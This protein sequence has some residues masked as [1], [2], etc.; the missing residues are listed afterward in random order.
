MFQFCI[1]TIKPLSQSVAILAPAWHGVIE[2]NVPGQA[3]M[4]SHVVLD[5]HLS[6][7]LLVAPSGLEYAL[8]FQG[9][10][11]LHDAAISEQI[12]ELPESQQPIE[13]A[14]KDTCCKSC[15]PLWK[16]FKLKSSIR[17][18]G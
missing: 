9:K 18:G 10:V 5:K 11:S 14:S 8:A 13:K 2:D 7:S 17:K 4:V 6:V 15:H 12:F 1:G 3:T 16:R